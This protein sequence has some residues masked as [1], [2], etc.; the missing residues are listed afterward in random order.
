MLDIQPAT[1]RAYCRVAMHRPCFSDSEIKSLWASSLLTFMYSSIFYVLIDRLTGLLG[2]FKL[3]RLSRLLLTHRRSLDGMSIWSDDVAAAQ[4][5][6]DGQVEHRQL[7]DMP[8][9][10]AF[11]FDCREAAPFFLLSLSKIAQPAVPSSCDW[12]LDGT[13]SDAT[14]SRGEGSGVGRPNLAKYIYQP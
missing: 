5:A 12:R 11:L 4:L 13:L 6:V 3:G 9:S 7:T 14:V 10:T 2:Q 1:R 8:A